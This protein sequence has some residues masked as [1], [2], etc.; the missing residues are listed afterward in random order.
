MRQRKQ[1]IKVPINNK[2]SN[3]HY[4]KNS[5]TSR[6]KHTLFI[7]SISL[8]ILVFIWQCIKFIQPGYVITYILND[9][10]TRNRRYVH[11]Q[12]VKV[13]KFLHSHKRKYGWNTINKFF[14]YPRNTSCNIKELPLSLQ[15]HKFCGFNDNCN[16]DA[17][18]HCPI[19]ASAFGIN[20]HYPKLEFPVNIFDN[21]WQK[22]YNIGN[23][24][25][26]NTSFIANNKHHKITDAWELYNERTSLGLCNTSAGMWSDWT[27]PGYHKCMARI[28]G[29]KLQFKP[30]TKVLDMGSGCG[31]TLIQWTY[32][33]GI[34][35]MGFDFQKLNVIYANNIAMKNN[36]TYYTYH[37][38]I[39][40]IYMNN[41]IPNQSFDYIFSNAVLMYIDRFSACLVIKKSIQIL[42]ISGTAWFAWNDKKR[43][44]NHC[45]EQ[46]VNHTNN[47]IHIDYYWLEE[48]YFLD[49]CSKTPPRDSLIIQ[50]ID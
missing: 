6:L 42:K 31:H 24:P 28:I 30:G 16:D 8:F 35:G 41:W 2:Q 12:V 25:V 17:L 47:S 10:E 20:K 40:S 37:A 29:E 36:L 1:P 4:H 32:W 45:L 11:S 46:Y 15:T 18:C 50:R 14:I 43:G 49:T 33:F 3:Q 27:K 48:P 9:H 19:N 39:Q 26:F 38:T 23:P 13:D 22:H 21:G 5:C 7:I 44:L 34:F